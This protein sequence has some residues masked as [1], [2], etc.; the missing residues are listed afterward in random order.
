MATKAQREAVKRYDAAHTVQFKI[1]LNIATDA[2]IIERLRGAEN[3]QGYIKNLI[4]KDIK[5]GE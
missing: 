2:D 3:V 4:R 1:K 5:A